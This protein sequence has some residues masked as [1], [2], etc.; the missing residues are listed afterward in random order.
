M[1]KSIDILY[2]TP[3][4]ST[5]TGALFNAFSYPTKISPEAEAIFIACHTKIGDTVLDPFGGSGTT[6]IATLL[7]DCPTPEMLEK[8]KELGLKPKWGPR[9][10]IVYELS[11]MG[12]LLGKVMCTTKSTQFKRHAESLLKMASDIC[13]NVYTIKDPDGNNGL[14]RHAIWSDMIICPFCGK[15]FPYAELAVDENPLKFREDSIC[16]SCGGNIHLSEVERAKET[17]EDP[18]LHES[19]SVKK[20]RLYKL[21]GSTGKRNWSRFATDS[22]QEVYDSMMK[23]R[24][25]SSSPIYKIKWGELYRQGYHYGIT[26]LHHFY[27][28]RNWFVFNT[29]WR[30]IDQFPKEIQDALRIFLLSYNTAHST[31]MT[32]VVAKKNN[33]DFV[34]TGAQPGVLYISGLPVEKNILLG[35]QRKL[36]TFVEAFQKIESSKGAVVFVNG[37]STNIQLEDNTIDYVFTDPPFGDFIPY[38]EINQ[39]NEAWMGIVTDNTE[40]AIINPA[41]G[42]AIEEYSNLMTSVFA[43][44]S[45]KMKATASCT[46]VFHS[47]KSAIWRALVDAYKQ[48]GLYSVKASILDKKQPS[49]KQTNSNV[50]VKGDPLILLKKDDEEV[51]SNSLFHNDK[52]LAQF[53]KEQAPTPY[54]KDIAV[55]TFSKYIMMCIEHN[56]TITLD[57][58]YFF[59]HET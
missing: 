8:V 4:P 11:P 9:K 48:S 22:D 33:P 16:P 17:I 7:T 59:E 56:Y 13:R 38:S 34:I 25:I 46:L 1:S 44:I 28:Y 10:A 45:R 37:S 57:A 36:K 54:N 18:L 6:G 2:N 50:T 20:R 32:R 15:E 40:E 3:F 47:A 19:V 30:K 55:K 5:R 35:L 58:K 51:L 39:I 41:Q 12:C 24:N 49:F 52:E 42:K 23:D 29:L 26:H 21:Y 27:T 31:L 43:Q 53:L 14:L